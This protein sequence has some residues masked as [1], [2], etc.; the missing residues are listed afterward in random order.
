[1]TKQLFSI[2]FAFI[3]ITNINGQ[4]LHA[5]WNAKAAKVNSCEYDIVLTVTIDPQYHIYSSVP[6]DGVGPRA[7]EIHFK[8]NNSYKLVGNLKESKPKSE[9]DEAFGL[10]VS[11]FEKKAVF[12][13]RVKVIKPGSVVIEGTYEYEICKDGACEFPPSFKFSVPIT[14]AEPCSGK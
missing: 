3:T 5:K 9:M 6:V 1:M 10:T 2:L 11:Y 13:Q 12:T 14:D 8:E 7:T 4:Q